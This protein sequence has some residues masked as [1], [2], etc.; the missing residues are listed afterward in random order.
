MGE[1]HCGTGKILWL[2]QVRRQAINRYT[3]RGVLM[4]IIVIIITLTQSL[5]SWYRMV[6][7]HVLRRFL[8]EFLEDDFAFRAST[9]VQVSL[10]EIHL[11]ITI[12]PFN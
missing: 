7:S 6:I 1:G 3:S 4:S 11:V 10:T 12:Q 5:Q 2:H 8:V 9:L